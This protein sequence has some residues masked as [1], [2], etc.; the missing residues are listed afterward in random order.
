MPLN[1]GLSYI[2][3]RG[4]RK[5]VLTQA[6]TVPNSPQLTDNKIYLDSDMVSVIFTGR[7]T[8]Q[9]VLSFVLNVKEML[10]GAPNSACD[11]CV[12]VDLC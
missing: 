11:G 7:I 12:S 8:L 5:P 6:P 9:A 3:G 10:T 1:E 2:N 4:Y